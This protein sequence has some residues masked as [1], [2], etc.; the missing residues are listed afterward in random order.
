MLAGIIIQMGRFR[1]FKHSQRILM[2][3]SSLV[4]LFF[5]I[6]LATQFFICFFMNRP[7]RDRGS[8]VANRSIITLTRQN[9]WTPKLRLLS[10]AM[11]F[12]SATLMI[13][14]V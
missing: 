2:V 11:A 10:A 1:R 7:V 6:L 9:T 4:A 5:F 8:L 14:Y 3:V 13:R 12:S